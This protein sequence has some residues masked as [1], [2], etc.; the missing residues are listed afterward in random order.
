[1]VLRPWLARSLGA[2][3]SGLEDF[4]FQ[5][6]RKPRAALIASS[7]PSGIPRHFSLRLLV[8]KLFFFFPP[9]VLC[10]DLYDRAQVPG[11]EP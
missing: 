4:H 8:D 3:A 10:S 6:L 11:P 1:M 9:L 5:T 7:P 2:Q